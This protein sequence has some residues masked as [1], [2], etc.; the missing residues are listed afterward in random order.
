MGSTVVDHMVLRCIDSG[1]R[2]T[3]AELR[4]QLRRH[5]H[6]L[7][8]ADQLIVSIAELE[9][10]GLLTTQMRFAL[11]DEGRRVARA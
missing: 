4:Y 9:R 6:P 2:L 7:A 10:D 5:G 3:E 1:L 11:T 8:E